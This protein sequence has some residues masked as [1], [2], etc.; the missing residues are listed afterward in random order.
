[1]KEATDRD[2]ERYKT[3]TLRDFLQLWQPDFQPNAITRL[4][5]DAQLREYVMKELFQ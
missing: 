2:P 4:L 5:T 1:M 3:A